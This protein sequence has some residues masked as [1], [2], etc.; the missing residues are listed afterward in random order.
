MRELLYE[1]AG[2][3]KQEEPTWIIWGAG[4]RGKA[5]LKYIL[6]LHDRTLYFAD[7]DLQKQG[8]RIENV[9][10]L[11]TEEVDRIGDRC[12]I[13]LSPYRSG[14]LYDKLCRN[15]PYVIADIILEILAYYPRANGYSNFMPLG[16][17]YSLYPDMDSESSKFEKKYLELC[18]LDQDIQDIDLN[19]KTQLA[20]LEKM[21]ELI[22]SIPAWTDGSEYANSKYRYQT[23]ATA[24]CV[25]DATC[26]HLM[27]RLLKP[28]RLIEVGSGWSSAVTLDTNEFYMNN[29]MDISFIE[30]YP[31][32]LN[33]IL[34]EDDIYEIKKCGLE[35]VD[36][37]YFGQLEKG[38][39]LFI[40]STHVS[41]IGSDVNYLLFE[42]LPRLKKGV[43]IHFHDIFYPFEY[44]YEWYKKEGWIWNELYMLRAFLMN[45]KNY[46][47]IFFVD[48]L[49][50]KYNAKMQECLNMNNP[51][52][53]SLWIEKM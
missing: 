29:E 49:S 20:Y 30:P 51:F 37:S 8:K 19:I 32:T 25:P 28:A 16:H 9:L 11:S 33:K 26:L 43:Y 23:N 52:G 45:N 42:I 35:E 21:K 5:L 38:D 48:Y 46:R 39:I 1:L 18:R 22:S 47:I 13:L 4:N 17:Y 50:K 40:D 12:I 14:D 44:P 10:C 3:R 41:K 27:L 15:F 31:D 36:L 2:Y 53:G 34:K 24:F 7:N 6:A